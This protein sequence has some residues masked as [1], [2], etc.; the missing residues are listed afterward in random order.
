MKKCQG[1]YSFNHVF[2]DGNLEAE[3]NKQAMKLNLSPGHKTCF[4]LIIACWQFSVC[5]KK[6]KEGKSWKIT[7]LIVLLCQND[8][9]IAEQICFDGFSK[10]II[11]KYHYSPGNRL[12]M[13]PSAFT[14]CSMYVWISEIFSRMKKFIY[15]RWRKIAPSSSCKLN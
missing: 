10:V 4:D 2:F 9:F 3:K 8:R 6:K 12:F 5:W 13:E 14:L 11:T 1:S 7:I 15:I